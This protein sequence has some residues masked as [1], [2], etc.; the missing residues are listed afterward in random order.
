MD[1]ASPSS[2]D[3]GAACCP[4]LSLVTELL[5]LFISL[6]ALAAS[7][8]F[9]MGPDHLQACPLCIYQ[10]T[11]LM[12]VIAALGLGRLLMGGESLA[13]PSLLALPLAVSGLG[14]AGFHVYLERT[15]VLVCPNGMWELGSIPE[16]AFGSFALVTMLLLISVLAA[17]GGSAV[18][19]PAAW[20]LAGIV[21][22]A[23][24]TT[25]SIR[26]GPDLPARVKSLSEL[27]A[28]K[29]SGELKG[30]TPIK[31]AE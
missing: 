14:V 10:R 28:L 24:F 1:T 3:R 7:L 31:K 16:Q 27:Q 9:S 5:A 30:C 18:R 13:I 23:G 4:G 29:S 25:A 15:E 22:G 26:S 2:P 8:Y 6:G 11:F 21:L 12:G 20:A 19:S 17:R